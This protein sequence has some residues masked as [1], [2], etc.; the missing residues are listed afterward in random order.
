MCTAAQW[1][2]AGSLE[3]AHYYSEHASQMHSIRVAPAHTT[4]IP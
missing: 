2:A 4:Y 3:T 1:A